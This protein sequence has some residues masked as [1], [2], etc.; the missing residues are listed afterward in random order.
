MSYIFI[1]VWNVHTLTTCVQAGL[2]VVQGHC[3][4]VHFI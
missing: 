3:S 4:T 1:T 2:Q